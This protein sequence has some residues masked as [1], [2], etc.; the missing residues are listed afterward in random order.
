[1]PETVAILFFYF[2]TTGNKMASLVIH[3]QERQ[4]W[5]KK[6]IEMSL[7]KEAVVKDH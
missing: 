6:N 3:L 7:G 1:L 5:K 4:K 2:S